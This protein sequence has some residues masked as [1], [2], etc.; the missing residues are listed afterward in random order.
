MSL[1]FLEA[2]QNV[3]KF[4][5][6]QLPQNNIALFLGNTFDSL[7]PDQKELGMIRNI[8]IMQANANPVKSAETLRA[9]DAIYHAWRLREKEK[10]K[11]KEG[12]KE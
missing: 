5:A 4:S 11:E 12:G 7:F 9:Y 10:E 3:G 1:N 6:R 8:L 2:M